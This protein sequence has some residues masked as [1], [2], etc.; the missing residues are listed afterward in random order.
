MKLL[1][2]KAT[3][4]WKVRIWTAHGQKTLTTKCQNK[5]DAII[6]AN[7]SG[8][9]QAELSA[10]AGQLSAQA[11]SKILTGRKITLQGAVDAW[12]ERLACRGR[13]QRTVHNYRLFAM[14]FVKKHRTLLPA[15]ITEQHINDWLNHKT[16]RQ[17]AGSRSVRLTAMRSFLEYCQDKGWCAGNA[18]NLVEIN[19]TVLSHEQKE[20]KQRL[21]FTDDEVE[22]LLEQASDNAS[23]FW[24]AAILI[25]RHLGLRLGDIA[26]LEWACFNKPGKIIVWTDKHDR[27]VELPITPQQLVV[28]FSRIPKA[29]RSYLF[30]EQQAIAADVARRA[31]LSTQF[32]RLCQKAGIEGK[33]FHSLRHAFASACQRSGQ[34]IWYISQSLG[35]SRQSTTLSYI[36]P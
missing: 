23:C 35:H 28:E 14:S 4:V 6:V 12:L 3:G 22:T 13:S 5:D 33:S 8:L 19:Y 32:S 21:P 10:R 16:N 2:D 31:T 18:A 11:I 17:K 25:G 36:H 34:P 29:H 1:K 26:S 9:K 24:H 15:S 7:E 30:P 20:P 27:R